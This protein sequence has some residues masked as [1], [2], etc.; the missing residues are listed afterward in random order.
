[1]RKLMLVVALAIA[2]SVGGCAGTKVGDF[3]S[4][5]TSTITNPVKASDVYA[6]KNAYAI[7]SEF[8]AEYRRYCYS[9]PYKVLLADPVAKPICQSRRDVIRKIQRAEANV[10]I[11][12]ARAEK[13][14]RE[15]PT[16]NAAAVIGGIWDALDAY[17]S[18]TP[19]VPK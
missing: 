18:A 13:F 8:A 15:N 5:A 17:R 14:I 12:V 11:A 19:A 3:I 6:A 10:E 4:S 2:T 9:K 16:L 7:A 1:M